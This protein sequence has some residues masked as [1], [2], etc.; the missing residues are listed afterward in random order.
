MEPLPNTDAAHVEMLVSGVVGPVAVFGQMAPR[1]M[2]YQGRGRCLHT[3]GAVR[4]NE[5]AFSENEASDT[6]GRWVS[7]GCNHSNAQRNVQ[8]PDNEARALAS[9]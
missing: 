2:Q 9:R 3:R 6:R 4:T 1:V 7:Q 8:T 5:M